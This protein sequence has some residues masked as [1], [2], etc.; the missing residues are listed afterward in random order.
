[1]G[2]QVGYLGKIGNPNNSMRVY[3]KWEPAV[4]NERQ[5]ILSHDSIS[6]D[7]WTK[8]LVTK[9]NEVSG[10]MLAEWEKSDFKVYPNDWTLYYGS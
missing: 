7:E 1:M 10:E 3:E 5:Y 6:K 8:I 9:V 2:N 4:V